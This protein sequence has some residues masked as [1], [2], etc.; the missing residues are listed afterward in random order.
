MTNKVR[1]CIICGKPFI[2]EDPDALICPADSAGRQEIPAKPAPEADRTGRKPQGLQPGQTLLDTY[3]VIG[4]L[5]EGGMGVVY[6]LH[7]PGWNLDLA[8][9][10]PRTDIFQQQS[11][12]VNFTREA[13]TWVDLGLH[14]QI[15]TCYYVRTVEE[16]PH[17]FVEYMAGGS[18]E[19]WIQRSSHDLYAGSPDEV[20]ARIL[21]I[22]I[23]FA[24][25]LAY[26]HDQGLVHRDVKPLNVLMTPEGVAK[27]TD[28]GLAKARAA[29][30]EMPGAS[31]SRA[32]GSEGLCTR[33]YR[34]PEQARHAPLDLKTDLWSWALSVLEMFTGGVFWLDGQAGRAILQEHLQ[35]EQ[36]PLLP[37]IPEPLLELLQQCLHPDPHQRPA[38][39][40]A[41]AD[42]L[43]Q[44]YRLITGRKVPGEKPQPARLLADSLNNKAVSMFDLGRE[45][46]AVEYWQ[47]AEKNN[48]LHPETI[49]NY[50]YWL[51]QNGR[52]TDETY[53]NQ[54]DAVCSQYPQRM[55][56]TWLAGMV[57]TET[58]D[59]EQAVPR[60]EKAW[61]SGIWQ[62]GLA[63]SAALCSM[64]KR[65]EGRTVLQQVWANDSSAA[66]L[67]L[68]SPDLESA[69]HHIQDHPL[70]WRRLDL[71]LAEKNTLNWH[72][73]LS[74]TPDGRFALVGTRHKP[75]LYDLEQ[76]AEVST[77]EKRYKFDT[78]VVD[79]AISADGTQAV[80]L[81]SDQTLVFWDAQNGKITDRI[82]NLQDYPVLSAITPDLA[83]LVY[84]DSMHV[85]H[86]WDLKQK[87]CL[88][89]VQIPVE[90]PRSSVIINRQIAL[91]ADGRLCVLALR[92]DLIGIRLPEG[93]LLFQKPLVVDEVFAM[94]M[95]PNGRV[96]L[97]G[98]A[99]GQITLWDL[100]TWRAT[101]LLGLNQHIHRLAIT[102]DAH[103][104]LSA[105]QGEY[106][107]K[108]N[109]IRLWDLGK[110]QCLWT[111][112]KQPEDLYAL[113]L[114]EDASLAYSYGDYGPLKRFHIEAGRER[115][116]RQYSSLPMI[117][118]TPLSGHQVI[119][120]T[121]Q[122][123]SRL[124][125]AR[126]LAG[127]GQWAQAYAELRQAQQEGQDPWRESLLES[128]HSAG[129]HGRRTGL[130]ASALKQR[131]SGQSGRI[132][133]LALRPNTLEAVTGG[134]GYELWW[135][136][137][138]KG[139]VLGKYDC[140]KT[141]I[142]SIA[143]DPTGKYALAG[144]GGFNIYGDYLVRLFSFRDQRFI[145]TLNLSQDAALRIV[146]GI[147]ET[148]AAVLSGRWIYIVNPLSGNIYH[149]LKG[150]KIFFRGERASSGTPTCLDF[151]SRGDRAI[152]GG[153]DQVVCLWDLSTGKCLHKYQ[154]PGAWLDEL[155]IMPGEK[156]FLSAHNDHYLRLWDFS[157]DQP[158]FT[159]DS[160][161]RFEALCVT[162]D[163]RF[164]FSSGED[165]AIKLWDLETHQQVGLLEAHSNL[166]SGLGL[167]N[168]E[169]WLISS[170]W[171]GTVC[172]WELDWEVTFP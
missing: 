118:A 115:N 135:W 4:L 86:L 49:F 40:H 121:D 168:N 137:L 104:A 128:L 170:S 107:N 60:L 122:S 131:L 155:L 2:S 149:S 58:G 87:K 70:P 84:L 35:A 148:Q 154:A 31:S 73:L 125:N 61:E 132:F 153:D 141:N 166:V 119:A 57:L 103:Y 172:I 53:L 18:L 130:H 75:I 33:E 66:A 74:I 150:H 14:P 134:D 20:L 59:L 94:A 24:W 127:R 169:R 114:S 54:I 72:H 46:T 152:S 113:H 97:M 16:I 123:Q 105:S 165:N 80:T 171:D 25:G 37:A 21:D 158:L 82:K 11:S 17:I 101:Q 13:E 23:Q 50:G 28:F 102:P 12:K 78:A 109:A 116:A 77:L 26:A 65:K 41:I 162:S 55:D 38:S 163:G 63:L 19:H 140:N 164:V 157:Q 99:K 92:D 93:Q 147:N 160:G 111:S 81:V 5:G 76:G 79:Q 159:I 1:F 83:R 52:Q 56:L 71:T 22:A 44:I 48:P 145:S 6:R 167:A 151:F 34:S 42:D 68:R 27:V 100:Q 89:S 29:A 108:E 36:E 15:A 45:E 142:R 156:H 143:A 32:M 112:E 85:L 117:F 96:L 39:M 146:Y 51:W 106:L 8:V 133:S 69:W 98:G 3:Q 30:G 67:K 95:T 120:I 161:G 9:K 7:H 62:A 136:D 124:D 126:E 90:V 91:S 138:H 110:R 88:L 10:R 43:E 129:S 139:T 144:G 64:G 47:A